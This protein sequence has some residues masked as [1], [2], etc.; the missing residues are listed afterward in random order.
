MFCGGLLAQ[1]WLVQRR[2][3][4]CRLV[5]RR[6]ARAAVSARLVARR[7]GFAGQVL[8]NVFHRFKGTRQALLALGGRTLARR[9]HATGAGPRVIVHLVFERLDLRLRVLQQFSQGL[10]ASEAGRPGVG[11]HAHPVVGNPVQ[12]DQA[13]RQ[14]R[15]HSG[16]ELAARP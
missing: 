4:A 7:V 6:S 14:Q 13:L 8:L 16:G 5:W 11:A 2:L 10:G 15:S 3:G 1:W 9:T 12:A